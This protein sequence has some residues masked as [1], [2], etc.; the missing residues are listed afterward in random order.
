[1]NT[2]KSLSFKLKAVFLKWSTKLK[3]N[4]Q[5]VLI[6]VNKKRRQNYQI[7]IKESSAQVLHNLT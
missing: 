1:M 2:E 3:E 5:V 7:G 6:K 4:T